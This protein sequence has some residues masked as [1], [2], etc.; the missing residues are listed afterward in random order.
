MVGNGHVAGF[1]CLPIM[2]GFG[3]LW[4]YAGLTEDKGFLD[5]RGALFRPYEELF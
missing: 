4:T 2:G 3:L 1:A 5:H